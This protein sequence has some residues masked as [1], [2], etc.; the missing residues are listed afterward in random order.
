[1]IYQKEPQ[2]FRV[3]KCHNLYFKT[4][5]H[6]QA[7][8]I[9]CTHGQIEL[10][11]EEVSYLLQSGDCA[12]VFPNR[13]H[14]Y[15]RRH[16]DAP[17]ESYLAILPLN[18]VED[19]ET[20]LDSTVPVHPIVKSEHL[21]SIFE[22]AFLSLY[23]AFEQKESDIRLYKGFANVLLA[24]L[25]PQLTLK[26]AANSYDLA[27][28]PRILN[29]LSVNLDT[30]LSLT[31]TAKAFGI[32]KNT[33]SNIFTKELHTT[34]LTY[35][36]NLRLDHARRLLKKTTLSVSAIAFESGFQSERSFY[37]IFR[38]QM[39]CTPRQYRERKKSAKK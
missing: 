35:V 18:Y 3:L 34:Y 13:P 23:E 15:L 33:L 14:A 10:I 37:R 19:F 20:E 5:F 12:I 2:S 21:P 8:L 31:Q 1:M 26:A 7:E 28:T 29:Y 38:E 30:P 11:I 4:H 39:H 32:S 36:N 9:Y 6:P 16:E 22:H 27:L 24:C 25:L 17:S